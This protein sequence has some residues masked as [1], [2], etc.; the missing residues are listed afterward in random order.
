LLVSLYSVKRL[1]QA[2]HGKSYQLPLPP[3]SLL[4]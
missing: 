2:P 1:L 3:T 4:V